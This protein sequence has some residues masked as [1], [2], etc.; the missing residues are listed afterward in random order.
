[1]SL[2]DAH[3]Q[4]ISQACNTEAKP[5]SQEIGIHIRS[6]LGTQTVEVHPWSTVRDVLWQT[7]QTLAPADTLCAHDIR[8]QETITVTA[9]GPVIQIF[10]R[11]NGDTHATRTPL[12]AS[13]SAVVRG[14]VVAGTWKES[15]PGRSVRWAR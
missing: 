1:M 4:V 8:D 15:P 2:T 13:I 10:V 14:D 6:W 7:M 12:Q 11:I 9:P 5:D 3:V